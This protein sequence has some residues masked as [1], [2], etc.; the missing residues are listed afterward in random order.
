MT[1]SAKPMNGLQAWQYKYGPLAGLIDAPQMALE[2]MDAIMR[3]H[4]QK[5][6]PERPQRPIITS[7]LDRP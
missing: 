3:A 7:R 2:R 5:V 1:T 4:E 6:I